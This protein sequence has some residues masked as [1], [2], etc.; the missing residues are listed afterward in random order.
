MNSLSSVLLRTSVRVNWY[1][2]VRS[3]TN[4]RRLGYQ[5]YPGPAKQGGFVIEHNC[6]CRALR[7]IWVSQGD[8]GPVRGVFQMVNYVRG[9]IRASLLDQIVE[10][11]A[12]V[13]IEIADLD[14]S[15]R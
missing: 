10:P 13:F 6:G 5:V 3:E 14:R 12:V 8:R 11:E 15:M 7:P 4:W 2:V 1:V 9:A